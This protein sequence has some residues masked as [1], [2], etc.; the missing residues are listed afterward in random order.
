M[1]DSQD[2]TVQFV[3]PNEDSEPL[4]EVTDWQVVSVWNQK[5]NCKTCAICMES[6]FSKCVHCQVDVSRFELTSLSRNIEAQKNQKKNNFKTIKSC[7]IMYGKCLHAFH[8]HCLQG[9]ML[10]KKTCPI[11]IA[12][13]QDMNS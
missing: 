3:V 1:D 13:W 8:E 2:D 6:L 9:W 7:D 4:F 11:C 5:T 12:A 10:K